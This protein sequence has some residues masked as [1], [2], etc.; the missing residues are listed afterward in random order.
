MAAPAA[1]A[2]AGNETGRGRGPW[3]GSVRL[4][5]GSLSVTKPGVA[6]SVS[7]MGMAGGSGEASEDD[8]EVFAAVYPG[9]RRFAAVVASTTV[10]PDDLVQEAVARALAH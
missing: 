5:V 6:V 4:R 10:D 2:T 3:E 7:S 9:L 8:A 1:D